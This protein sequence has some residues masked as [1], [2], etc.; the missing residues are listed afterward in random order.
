MG[1]MLKD[2]G[3]HNYCISLLPTT[4]QLFGYVEIESEEKWAQVANTEICKK[5][6]KWMTEFIVFNEDMTPASTPLKE[7]FF[8]P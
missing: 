7:M 1:Q 8:L 4:N 2:H 3:A 5:W 6:W